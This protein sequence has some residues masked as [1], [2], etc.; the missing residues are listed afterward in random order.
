MTIPNFNLSTWAGL[1]AMGATIAAAWN[2]IKVFG[3]YLMGLVIGSII[4]KDEAGEA[5]MA[6][7]F[8]KAKRSPLGVRV[9]GGWETYVHPKRWRETVGYEGLTSDPMIIR[10][11][12]GLVFISL[13]GDKNV[14]FGNYESGNT[15][16]T[17]RFFRWFFKP[18]KFL[19]EAF[20]HYNKEKRYRGDKVEKVKC[21]SYSRFRLIRAGANQGPISTD[22]PAGS[23]GRSRPD[24]DDAPSPKSSNYNIEKLLMLGVY[25]LLN[26][27]REDLQLQ[28]EEGQSPF[29]GYPFPDKVGEAIRELE[30]WLAH[31][32]W[33]RS[34]SIPWRRGWLLHGPPGTGKS[35]LVR[36]LGM[37]FKLPVYIYDLS[38]MRNWELVECWENMMSETPVIALIEDIDTVFEGREFVGSGRMGDRH[39]PTAEHLTFDCLLNCIS[40][41]RSTDGVFLI[42][43]TNHIDKVDAALGIPDATGK[44]TRPGRIDRA[45]YLG[46]MAEP[47]RRLLATH[48]LSDYPALVEE[49]VK[50]G[51]GETAAQFQDRCAKAATDRFWN[52][53]NGSTVIKV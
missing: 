17:I 14:T 53:K 29:T 11:G 15:T 6:F 51:K 28:P 39:S 5:V 8:S 45:I 4:V 2:Q 30:C 36:A 12:Y 13:V 20:D 23:G 34:K 49:T 48:I 9:F 18:D 22:R 3:R 41:V 31:E 50:L 44:S 38:P 27:K 43:T 40:G 35:T 46:N 16:L 25:R 42:V 1:V 10:Y 47:Q 26:W 7:C 24:N 32:Q 37:S 21:A 33:F 52:K 19:I